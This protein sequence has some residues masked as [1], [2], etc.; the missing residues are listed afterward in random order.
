[1]C[2]VHSRVTPPHAQPVL[3]G[4]AGDYRLVCS[5]PGYEAAGMHGTL[6]VKS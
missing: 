3:R 1:M 4:L 5:Q 6:V 2:P